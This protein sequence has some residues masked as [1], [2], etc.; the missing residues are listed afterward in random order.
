MARWCWHLIL[1]MAVVFCEVLLARA[2]LLFAGG[3]VFCFYLTVCEGWLPGLLWG[4]G[5]CLAAETVLARSTTAL[6]WLL[7]VVPLGLGWRKYGDR[8]FW[9][10]QA[11]PAGV[12]GLVHAGSFVLL[13]N[14]TR[15]GTFYLPPMEPAV[16]LATGT[17]GAVVGMPLLMWHF[18]L[19]A[20]LL[21]YPRF[22]QKLH[23][24]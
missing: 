16:L 11:L 15:R 3:F 5:A 17:A 20:Q 23:N 24:G 7:L 18:D 6:P 14:L 2:G 10:T 1:M 19:G 21:G 13:E 4:A 8:R 22:Y 12:L 9:V